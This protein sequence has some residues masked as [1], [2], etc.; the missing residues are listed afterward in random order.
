MAT[1]LGMVPYWAGIL[2]AALV[3]ACEIALSFAM[4]QE[5]DA[6]FVRI[7]SLV[8]AAIICLAGRACRYVL[9]GN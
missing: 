5:H 7:A 3:L 1:R 6:W 8:M 9:A 2:F 4:V